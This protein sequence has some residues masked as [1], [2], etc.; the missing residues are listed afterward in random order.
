MYDVRNKG[1]YATITDNI[2]TMATYYG[3]KYYYMA[4]C[5][6]YVTLNVIK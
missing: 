3:K 1:I 6:R 4:D 2:T 5:V